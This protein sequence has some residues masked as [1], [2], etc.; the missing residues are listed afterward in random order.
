MEENHKCRGSR[1]L[2]WQFLLYFSFVDLAHIL[3]DVCIF[4]MFGPGL[5]RFGRL[6]VFCGIC[7]NKA[8]FIG[9]I[10]YFD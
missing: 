10:V 5:Y 7:I 9:E 1:K 8:E 4:F 3:S 2:S 6:G